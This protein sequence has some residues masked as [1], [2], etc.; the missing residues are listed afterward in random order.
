M[1]ALTMN[2]IFYERYI[3]NNFYLNTISY[4]ENG[5]SIIKNNQVLKRVDFISANDLADLPISCYRLND[6]F[7]FLD[8]L[9]VNNNCKKDIDNLE[10][11]EDME[12]TKKVDRLYL[13]IRFI[14]I[15]NE[16]TLEDDQTIMNF[17]KKYNQLVN[18]NGYLEQEGI[19]TYEQ[20]SNILNWS[21]KLDNPNNNSEII[22]KQYIW[23]LNSGTNNEFMSSL[24]KNNG[25]G[26]EKNTS[27][28]R[29]SSNH[30]SVINEDLNMEKAGFF[31]FL[32]ILYIALN[33]LITLGILA[34]KK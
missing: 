14:L 6:A 33:L 31:S 27:L 23:S 1:A 2:E 32:G 34:I 8:V 15:K 20:M 29:T 4:D 24:D 22:I 7:Y 26:Q 25:N 11:D 5:L 18:C 10:T 21:L 30:P 9:E 13:P 12:L 17:I 3:K 16:S 28:I 19:T